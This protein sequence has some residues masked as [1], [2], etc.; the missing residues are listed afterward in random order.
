MEAT[1][2]T[3]AAVALVSAFMVITRRN[4]VHALLYLVVCLLSVAMLFFLLG[5]AFAAVLEVIVYAGAIVVLFVF[6]VMLLNVSRDTT[7]AGQWLAS[8]AWVGPVLLTAPLLIELIYLLGSAG[9][10]GCAFGIG[11]GRVGESLFGPYL[12]AVELAS[13]LLLAA[14][15]GA[16]HLARPSDGDS[17]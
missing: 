17:Q 6:V 3:S 13:L 16:F 9:P 15:V 1:F 7:V 5:A 10:A 12:L 11:P 14:L 4:A 8:Q 2:Y